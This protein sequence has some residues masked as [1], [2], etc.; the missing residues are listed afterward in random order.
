MARQKCALFVD[1]MVIGSCQNTFLTE[2]GYLASDEVT[3]LEAIPHLLSPVEQRR[4]TNT[5]HMSG[6]LAK[7][8]EAWRKPEAVYFTKGDGDRDWPTTYYLRNLRKQV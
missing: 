8:D 6:H 3:E 7:S 2:G 5:F 1:F 4:W